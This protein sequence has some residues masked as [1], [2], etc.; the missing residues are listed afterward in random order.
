MNPANKNQQ[1][2]LTLRALSGLSGDMML[3]GLARI[4]E[5]SNTELTELTN[6]LALPP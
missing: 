4:T 5:T 1:K 2:V 3:A 6:A